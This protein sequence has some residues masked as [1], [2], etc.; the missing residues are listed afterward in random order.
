MLNH[1]PVEEYPYFNL[2]SQVPEI[3]PPMELREQLSS[4]CNE[5]TLKAF[6]EAANH[7]QTAIQPLKVC[8]DFNPTPLPV[9]LS[10]T[11]PDHLICSP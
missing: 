1:Q 7:F 2:E 6:I 3:V 11:V 9:P 5:G 4:L 10:L 8:E